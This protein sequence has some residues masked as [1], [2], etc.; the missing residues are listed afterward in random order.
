MK[1]NAVAVVLDFVNP[2]PPWGALLF[3]VA[4]WGL[5]NPGI[6]K[7]FATNATHKKAAVEGPT[8]GSLLTL[9]PRVF[10]A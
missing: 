2:L 10:N 8:T 1:L 9:F 4:S 5:M 6:S 7:R 3:R